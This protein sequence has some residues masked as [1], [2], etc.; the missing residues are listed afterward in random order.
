MSQEDFRMTTN[1][2]PQ[3]LALGDHEKLTD[4]HLK[5]VFEI[6]FCSNYRYLV[7]IFGIQKRGDTITKEKG[8]KNKRTKGR[9]EGRKRFSNI[10]IREIKASRESV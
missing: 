2:A 9:K 6:V 8:R 3:F 7:S 4:Y 10:N 5:S 1:A